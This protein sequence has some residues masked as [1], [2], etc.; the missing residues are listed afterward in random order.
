MLAL[1]LT[2]RKNYVIYTNL[3]YYRDYKLWVERM[4]TFYFA[5]TVTILYFAR[6]MPCFFLAEPQ[7]SSFTVFCCLRLQTDKLPENRHMAGHNILKL[8]RTLDIA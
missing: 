6:S 5:I 3:L 4:I 7:S 2:W 1:L 8:E